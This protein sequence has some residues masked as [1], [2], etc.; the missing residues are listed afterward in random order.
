[1]KK[2]Y[3]KYNIV[4]LWICCVAMW[5]SAS[6]LHAQMP[7][8]KKQI[9]FESDSV[10]NNAQMINLGIRQTD[11]VD[12]VGAVS[13]FGSKQIAEDKTQIMG[14]GAV[15][16]LIRG[17]ILGL[18]NGLNVRGVGIGIDVGTATNATGMQPLVLI[19]G[20]PGDLSYLRIEEIEDITVL[21]DVNAAILYGTTAVNGVI[22]ITTKRGTVDKHASFTA[23]YGV[24]T[25]KA[26]PKYLNSADYME[27]YNQAYLNDGRPSAGIPFT[28]TQI[29]NYRN[30]NKFRYPDVDYFS[31]D[32]L[33]SFKD[34]FDLNGDISGGNNTA[35]YY[36]NLGW[37]SIGDIYNIGY[38]KQARDNTF[39]LRTNVD[40]KINDFIN[41]QNDIRVII[42][43][44]KMP[45]TSATSGASYWDIARSARPYEYSPLL[46][47]DLMDPEIPL[48]LASKRQIDG[49]YLLGGDNNN[50]TGLIGNMYALGTVEQV[51][52]TLSMNNRINVDLSR[53]A[54]GLSFHTNFTFNFASSWNQALQNQYRVYA[55]KW[56]A[57][58]D[59]II[60]LTSYGDDVKQ[61]TLNVNAPY[62]GRL[63]S[64]FASFNYDRVFNEIHHLTGTLLGYTSNFK[65]SYVNAIG[66]SN[67]FLPTFYQPLK[68][69]HL[70]LQLGYAY[71]NRY[72]IDFSSA[73][74]NSSKLAP[75]HRTGFAPSG[76]LAWMM[77]NEDFMKSVSFINQ[78][79]I[80]LSGGIL[81]S[82]IPIYDFFLYEDRY[83][84]VSGHTWDEGAGSRSAV[85]SLRGANLNLSFVN[86][87][88]LNIGVEALLLNKTVG[89]EA[90]VFQSLYDGLLASPT[91][92]YPNFFAPDFLP[93]R[94]YN[95][96][97]YQGGE[98]GVNY[99]WT[100]NN[101]KVFAGIN[102]LY[103][104]SI[105]TRVEEIWAY[106]YLK[107]EGHPADAIF[108]LQAI[109]LFKDQDDIYDSPAQLFGNPRQGD[110]KYK[111]QQRPDADNNI[112]DPVNDQ[113]YLGQ[114]Q[115]PLSGG[116]QFN[117][118]YK[119]VSL[120]VAGNAESGG[121]AF[122][123]G[124]Y[125]WVDG[126][127]KYSEV[128]RNAW[129]EDNS[130]KADYPRLTTGTSDNN[131]RYSTYWMYKKD[132]FQINRIQL[133]WR[134]PEKR[135]S[136]S[137]SLSSGE[138][139]GYVTDPLLLSQ[140][141]KIMELSHSGA[142]FFRSFILGLRISL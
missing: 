132:Y 87:K 80:R 10:V 26:M 12:L 5:I 59:R 76:G 74:V 50:Q 117:L 82:D 3:K 129:T 61:N 99:T 126:N 97:K 18:L 128:V 4:L 83:G 66:N 45:L 20:L 35:R 110:I 140:N 6:A 139:F 17:K 108:G 120:M 11:K 38:G 30:G 62:V 85:Q 58:D 103:S 135:L 109:G 123:E 96:T 136:K 71:K 98:A 105:R 122:R 55:P 33:K 141:S 44:N 91:S 29:D 60:D 67:G 84:T 16:D 27:A 142:P 40:L 111:M 65:Q 9:T 43:N 32:Y 130:K 53:F 34:F 107:R 116:I 69:A 78:L 31:G 64:G 48:L 56:D 101:W 23:R 21:K 13:T 104:T 52:R 19:D 25:P 94:N 125:Y 113:T 119:N 54:K 100:S 8:E 63:I 15:S 41:V 24:S 68:Q 114:S 92:L 134:L 112:I 14:S 89:F 102:V 86:R 121:I 131:F 42:D 49:L 70:G 37:Q 75:G 47:I 46:P 79:K 72:M 36:V 93:I 2:R 137:F 124:D 95:I 22:L 73:L 106:N 127:K 90:N 57:N 51:S 118:S 1:M 115:S 81:K 28:E 88:D 39:N 77:S 133:S 138:V 7:E